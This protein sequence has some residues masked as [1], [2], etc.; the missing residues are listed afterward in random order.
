MLIIETTDLKDLPV[1]KKMIYRSFLDEPHSNHTEQDSVETLTKTSAFVP[2]LSLTAKLDDKIVGYLLLYPIGLKG[3]SAL[4]ALG[5]A[6]LSVD[7]EYQQ[8]GIGS[9]LLREAHKRA[10]RSFDLITL[11]GHPTYYPKF[12][13]E[14]AHKHNI[15][16]PFDLPQEILMVKLLKE[17]L[18]LSATHKIVY[19]SPYF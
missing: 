3:P 4:N 2:H 9:A 11:V 1:I 13:Y 6:P 5:L 15:V 7:P 17:P 8:Q 16:F 18:D 10:K 19:P 12:G 14:P